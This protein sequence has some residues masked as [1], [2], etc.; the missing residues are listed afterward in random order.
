VTTVEA[1][2]THDH[3]D[4]YP[5][6]AF[7]GMPGIWVQR[8]GQWDRPLNVWLYRGAWR[9]LCFICMAPVSTK[10]ALYGYGYRSQAEAFDAALAH[11]RD[12]PGIASAP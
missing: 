2:V 11:C 12:C 10:D 8:H 3:R 9:V 6:R 7:V 4:G 1:K 5:I